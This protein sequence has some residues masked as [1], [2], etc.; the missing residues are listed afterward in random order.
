MLPDHLRKYSTTR[1]QEQMCKQDKQRKREKRQE[2]N[3]TQ[4]NVHTPEEEWHRA[5]IREHEKKTID[6]ARAAHS[7]TMQRASRKRT[8]SEVLT[9]NKVWRARK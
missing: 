1:W 6:E 3:G 4:Q 2:Q 8:R 9:P 5:L 7:Q